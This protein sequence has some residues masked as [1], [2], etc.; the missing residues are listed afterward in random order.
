[1]RDQLRMFDGRESGSAL[2]NPDFQTFAKA[3]G[4]QSWRVTDADGLRVALKE[5]LAV[6]APTLIEVMTDIGKEYAPWEFIAPARG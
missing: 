2:S 5:A 6:N 4:V 1:M 3:F